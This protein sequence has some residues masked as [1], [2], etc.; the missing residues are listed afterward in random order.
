MV[1]LLVSFTLTPMRRAA[2]ARRRRGGSAV[3]T[4]Q[5]AQRFYGRIDRVYASM[6]N[7]S[8]AHRSLIAGFAVI[9]ALSSVPLY[10]LVRQE[11]VPTVWTRRGSR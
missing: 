7:W 3:I 1:S 6:L 8:M 9:V 10:S 11:F 2:P 5:G 4:R